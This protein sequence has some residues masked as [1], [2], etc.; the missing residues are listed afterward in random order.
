MKNKIIGLLLAFTLIGAAFSYAENRDCCD[1]PNWYVSAT[2]S[3]GWH[4]DIKEK[5][6]FGH[7]F[8][9]SFK[10]N[11]GGSLA[12]GYIV[13]QW[14]LEIEGSYRTNKFDKVTLS[15]QTA[16][17]S[18]L[19]LD[20]RTL[21]VN[22]FYDIPVYDCITLY[23]GG[24]LGI[25]WVNFKYKYQGTTYTISSDTCFAYQLMA[26]VAYGLTEQVDLT[27]GYRL[28]GRTYA[29]SVQ[30]APISNNIEL[31]LRFKF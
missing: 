17:L 7:E 26:G 30:N 19:S 4:N 25:D 6:V 22:L 23:V 14:R 8:K 13:D 21:M 31:G 11:Y 9:F 15:G 24:G 5:D 1:K 10:N 16:A 29:D 18:N 20:D 28:F 27:L 3:F 12:V 2:G